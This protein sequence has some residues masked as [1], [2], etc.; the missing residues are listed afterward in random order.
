MNLDNFDMITFKKYFNVSNINGN[1]KKMFYV[2][3]F[4]CC[5]II[6]LLS[7]WHKVT[8]YLGIIFPLRHN[9]NCNSLVNWKSLQFYWRGIYNIYIILLRTKV[10]GHA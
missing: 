3:Y 9:F 5:N 10:F 8:G 1:L 7:L 4:F 6:A 2:T